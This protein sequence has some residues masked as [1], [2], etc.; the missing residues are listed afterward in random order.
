MKVKLSNLT[1][2][3][4]LLSLLLS[5]CGGT[6]PSAENAAA[7]D[8]PIVSTSNEIVAEGRIVPNESAQLSFFTNGQVAEIIVDEGDQVKKGDVVARLGNREEFEAALANAEVELI[9]AQ[10]ALDTLNKDVE[11]AR[12]NTL[13][14]IATANR[15]V[16]DAQYQLDNFTVAT[17]QENLTAIEGVVK[18]KELLD[19]ARANFEPYKFKAST[20]STRKDMKER[21][22]NAQS[23]YNS[24]V[25]RLEYE[26]ELKKAEANLEKA[27]QDYTDLKDG[28]NPDDVATAEAREKAAQAAIESAKAALSHLE[29]TST[30][31]GTVVKQDLIVGQQ[32]TAG[33][34]VITI[35]DFSQMY[36][37][38]DDLTEI[39][40][41][42]ISVG[43]KAS[44]V[45]DAI[46]DLEIS[47]TVDKIS[48][49]Y[50]EKRGDV[51]YTTR[52]LLDTI[53]PRL[54]WGMT[55]VITFQK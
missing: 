15:A 3:V 8:I 24:A 35:A 14:T 39:E 44:V 43:Q 25:R 38:T 4:I 49:V 42:D 6:N 53:D 20:D 27:N 22:D 18:M 1:I 40:V 28:P 13:E 16:R 45:P 32:V 9:A 55:V 21:L 36:A 46:P 34:P 7:T 37:E 17:S 2:L 51:T 41:V 48:D 33:Q 47:G 54:R 31:N 10:Q 19:K 11:V 23:D 5:A 29:L 52:I 12:A 26:T 50:E 30:L